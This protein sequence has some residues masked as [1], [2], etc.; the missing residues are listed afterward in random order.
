MQEVVML[1]CYRDHYGA[2]DV[3]DDT[4]SVGELVDYL[5]DNF[6]RDTKIM[7][8][9]HNMSSYGAIC[10]SRLELDDV[11]ESGDNY[12]EDDDED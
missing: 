10:G 2:V 4:M 3:L 11:R 12:D 9:F 6:N 8:R 7:M 1:D 5:T